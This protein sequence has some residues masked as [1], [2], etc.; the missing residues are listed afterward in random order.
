MLRHVLGIVAVS[1]HTLVQI[2]HQDGAGSFF[3]RFALGSG[4]V[5]FGGKDLII[6]EVSGTWALK[7]EA[8]LRDRKGRKGAR[9]TLQIGVPQNPPP[10]R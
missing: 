10:I 2:R 5:Y 8:G 6:S 1:V 7:A 3:G 9:L 4:G